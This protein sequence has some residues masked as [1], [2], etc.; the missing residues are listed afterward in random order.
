MEEAKISTIK[1]R[2][3]LDSKGRPMVEVDVWTS[4]GAFGRGT[5]PCGTST[6]KYEA[7]VLRDGGSRYGGLGVQKAIQNVN[8]K[9]APVLLGKSV[10]KQEEIDRIMIELDGTSNKSRLGA[11]AIY[12][13]S[14]AV[15]RAAAQFMGQPLYRYLGG[16]KD[17]L[18]PVPMF[19]MING[20]SA[21][22]T[23]TEFQEFLLIPIRA[24]NYS[25]ALRIGVEV[26][27]RLGS[28]IQKHY[29]KKSLQIGTSGGYVAPTKE[30]S[31]IIEILLEAAEDAGYGDICR[32]GLD[33][34]ASH[35]YIRE[36]DCY[37]L[38]G[39]RIN[40][41]ELIKMLEGLVKKYPIFFI[42]D[43]LHEDD[44]EGFA[45]IT[46]KINRLIAGDDLFVTNIERLKKGISMKA[47]NAMILKPNM[48]GTLTEAIKA[49]RFARKHGYQLI[50]S[51]R[52]GGGIDDPIPEIALALGATFIK[53]GA[54]RS[55]ERINK[56]NVLLRIEE[57]VG[58]SGHFAGAFIF[59]GD[60]E[61]IDTKKSLQF[62]VKE[63]RF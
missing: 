2:E 62:L 4:N 54:P 49:A 16:E 12:S 61:N 32:V 15:A 50:G 14:I 42:E 51:G 26:F 35:F 38:G 48:V 60:K 19:N 29:G 17:Y 39:K 52:N 24:E 21:S 20:K 8:E 59:R 3:I 46:K 22:E 23:V 44:F 40:Q 33:C 11:N 25:E 10:V 53:F 13:V 43:P 28:I 7:F 45:E 5:F 27:S 55:G 37:N 9:I 57:E 58:T 6:G 36:E 34:A 31:K 56:Y 63:N 30:I 1:A 47:A 41:N 18:L